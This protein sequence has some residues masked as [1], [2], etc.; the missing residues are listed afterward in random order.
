MRKK[1]TE[2]TASLYLVPAP[3]MSD[4]DPLWLLG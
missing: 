4:L 3:S 2:N 1:A